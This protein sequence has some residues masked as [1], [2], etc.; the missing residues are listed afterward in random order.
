MN[1][2]QCA[3]SQYDRQGTGDFLKKHLF[4]YVIKIVVKNT[5]KVNLYKNHNYELIN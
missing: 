4:L 3:G 1:Y 5:F 2:P